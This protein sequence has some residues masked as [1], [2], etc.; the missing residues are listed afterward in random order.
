[1]DYRD[2]E[3][4]RRLTHISTGKT[5]SNIRDRKEHTSSDPQVLIDL[6][7]S[8]QDI[9]VASLKETQCHPEGDKID[10]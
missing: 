6:N 4:A 1:V 10:G 9:I 5:R 8:K 3:T 2:L 7:Y